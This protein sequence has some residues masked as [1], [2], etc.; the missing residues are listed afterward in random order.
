MDVDEDDEVVILTNFGVNRTVRL[1]L[2]VS[3]EVFT[4]ELSSIVDIEP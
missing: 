2:L 1:G 3:C 4:L